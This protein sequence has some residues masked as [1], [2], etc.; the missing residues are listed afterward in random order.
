MYK[1]RNSSC[2]DVY[3]VDCSS[4]FE[5]PDFEGQAVKYSVLSTQ[6][7]GSQAVVVE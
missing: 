2:I 7:S 4:T 1:Q 6:A 5:S 3:H